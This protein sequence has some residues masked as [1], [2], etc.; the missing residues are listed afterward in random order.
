MSLDR[1]SIVLVLLKDLL[2]VVEHDIKWAQILN[3][4]FKVYHAFRMNR[5]TLI[6]QMSVQV[7]ARSYHELNPLVLNILLV[8]V[9]QPVR[10]PVE[11]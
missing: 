8:D 2:C 10:D 11:T 9:E 1:L 4:L 5:V 7:V 6:S 3:L